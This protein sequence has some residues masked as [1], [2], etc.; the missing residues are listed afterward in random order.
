MKTVVI[1]RRAAARAGLSA[2]SQKMFN[3]IFIKQNY[4]CRLAW[5]GGGINKDLGISIFQMGRD[6]ML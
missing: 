6:E 3:Y 5:E 2:P 1:S 4:S